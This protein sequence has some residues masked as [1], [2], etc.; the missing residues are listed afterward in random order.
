MKITLPVQIEGTFEDISPVYM[1]YTEVWGKDASNND[2]PV[3]WLETMAPV[4]SLGTNPSISL[5]SRILPLNRI[6]TYQSLIYFS[7]YYY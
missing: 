7:N 1:V 3:C 4:H 6:E 5:S 2:I